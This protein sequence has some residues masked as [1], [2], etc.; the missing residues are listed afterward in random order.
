MLDAHAR[1]VEES[2]VIR[3]SRFQSRV[4]P[5]IEIIRIT[6]HRNFISTVNQHALP[7]SIDGSRRINARARE[8]ERNIG[9]RSSP[10][11]ISGLEATTIGRLENERITK[12]HLS[13]S[14]N[15]SP[16]ENLGESPAV[17]GEHTT[18]ST[19]SPS[20][21][22]SSHS[23]SYTANQPASQPAGSEPTYPTDN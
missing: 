1:H 10:G 23:A 16:L 4:L 20:P 7:I 12:F 21:G 8:R 19:Y 2:Q 17:A 14:R 22:P 15:R 6:I 9:V 18:L 3:V 5:P 11:L 13:R